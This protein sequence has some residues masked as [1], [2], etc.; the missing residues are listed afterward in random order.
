[1]TN[2]FIVSLL[3]QTERAM[4][5]LKDG[6]YGNST[7]L[8]TSEGTAGVHD[9]DDDQERILGDHEDDDDFEYT[10]SNLS[11]S[12]NST[13][14]LMIPDEICVELLDDL[15]TQAKLY[16]SGT[17][18]DYCS[19]TEKCIHR[20]FKTIY[21]QAKFFSD[22]IEEFKFANFVLA[23]RSPNETKQSVQI[24]DWLLKNIGM[25]HYGTKQKIMF[26]KTY[27]K[28]IYKE[29]GKLRMG[30]INKFKTRFIKGKKI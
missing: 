6:M 20:Y 25:S 11:R 18:E 27:W 24:C 10:S 1:M 7:P 4:P 3:T 15:S 13:Q 8:N 5:D 12:T 16:K 22:S 30:D 26:W 28:S 14:E 23:S 19:D 29:L 9:E 17:E 21:R 2:A